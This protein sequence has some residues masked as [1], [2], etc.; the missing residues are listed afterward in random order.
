MKKQSL[1]L[2][3]LGLL[4]QTGFS[5]TLTPGSKSNEA[6]D[7]SRLAQIDTISKQYVNNNWL[8]GSVVLVVKDNQIIYY[9]GQ[10]FADAAS[11]KPMPANAIFRIMSQ[12]KAITSL[13]IMQLFEQGKFRLDQNISD[14]IPEF[15]NPKVLKDFNPADTSYTTIPADREITFR[16]LLTHT[17]GIDYAAIGS[18]KMTA[19]Y[20]KAGIPS[21][22][23]SFKITLLSA[24][25]KLGSLPLVHQPGEKFTYGL[26]ADLLGCLVEIISGTTLEE[27]FNKKQHCD[28]SG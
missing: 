17:S 15:K 19:I 18:D 26:N 13:A 27:Y 6:F 2:L 16:D 11:K 24:M 1:L 10:G 21:G 4:L 28:T 23:G 5:Q 8:V 22:L 9:K 3:I 20:A 12:T 25:Q 7:Y 14:F